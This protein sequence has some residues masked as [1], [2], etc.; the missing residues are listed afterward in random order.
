MNGRGTVSGA[1]SPLSTVH[2][3]ARSRELL[4][5]D[6]LLWG[7]TFSCRPVAEQ[8][9]DY[10][11]KQGEDQAQHDAENLTTGWGRSLRIPASDARR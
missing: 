8:C 10:E 6:P 9:R 11:D 7:Q 1:S 4:V 3:R 5:T 2:N